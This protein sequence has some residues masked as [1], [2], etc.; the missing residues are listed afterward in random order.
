MEELASLEDQLQSAKEQNEAARVPQRVET[1]Q[2]DGAPCSAMRIQQ[3]QQAG[4]GTAMWQP[5][6]IAPAAVT[7]CTC[8]FR[9]QEVAVA[10]GRVVEARGADGDQVGAAGLREGR[11]ERGDGTWG[12]GGVDLGG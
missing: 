5:P 8:T 11:L 6:H 12:L 1:M 4:G 3:V 10:A 2:V 7:T 9:G